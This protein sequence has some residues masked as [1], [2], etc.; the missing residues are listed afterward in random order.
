MLVAKINPI[1]QD[2]IIPTATGSTAPL[3][4]QCHQATLYWLYQEAFDADPTGD[5]FINGSFYEA[6]DD[7]CETRPQAEQVRF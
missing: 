2:I 4:I 7:D 1:M 3:A 5:A 6:D